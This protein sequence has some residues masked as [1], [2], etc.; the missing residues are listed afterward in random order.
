MIRIKSINLKHL[1]HLWTPFSLSSLLKIVIV[2]IFP[3]YLLI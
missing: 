2:I 1:K 3:A